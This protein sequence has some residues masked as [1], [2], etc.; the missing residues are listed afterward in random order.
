MASRE[1]PVLLQP[2]IERFG[3]EIVHETWLREI[4]TPATLLP[5][6]QEVL[7]VFSVLEQQSQKGS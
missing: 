5:T 2:L 1:Q 3:L 6:M 7:Q 4:G